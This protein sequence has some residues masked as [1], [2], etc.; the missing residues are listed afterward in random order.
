MAFS[1]CEA[2]SDRDGHGPAIAARLLANGDDPEEAR[3]MTQG[4]CNMTD[5]GRE[6]LG[7]LMIGES[8]IGLLTPRRHALLWSFGPG[9]YRAFME[10]FA[11]QP[12]A[13]RL[14]Y[15]A[16]LAG[17][18]WLAGNTL[19]RINAQPALPV[20]RERGMDEDAFR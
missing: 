13:A 5:R 10:R 1:R 4:R 2:A 8:I 19:S 7:M 11:R 12:G 9:C 20:D 3:L 15:A 17:G 14:F 18:A 16:E 6:L